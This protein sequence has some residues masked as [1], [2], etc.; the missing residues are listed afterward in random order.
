VKFA[1]RLLSKDPVHLICPTSFSNIPGLLIV[2]LSSEHMSEIRKL[3]RWIAEDEDVLTVTPNLI[4]DERM[5]WAEDM[6]ATEAVI[7]PSKK[8]GK[9]EMRPGPRAD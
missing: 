6:R 3:L 1:R 4:Y 2:Y 5:Y 7:R 8:A 9:K